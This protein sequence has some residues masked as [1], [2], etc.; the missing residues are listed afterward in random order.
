MIKIITIN[1]D[2]DKNYDYT[3]DDKNNGD[4][5]KNNSDKHINANNDNITINKIYNKDNVNNGNN[6]IK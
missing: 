1:K 6:Y 4:K 2:D 5:G 3:D